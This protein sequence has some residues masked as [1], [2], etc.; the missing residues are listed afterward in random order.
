MK[1][2]QMR[3][4]G[5]G[6]SVFDEGASESEWDVSSPD[7]PSGGADTT[8]PMWT[9]PSD[10]P[11]VPVGYKYCLNPAVRGTSLS[12]N[13]PTDKPGWVAEHWAGK[14]G[15]LYYRFIKLSSMGTKIDE[16]WGCPKWNPS[17]AS[18]ADVMAIQRALNSAGQPGANGKALAVDGVIGQ[19]TCY[20]MYSYVYRT[21]G[22]ADP[23]LTETEFASLGLGG[24]GFGEKYARLCDTWYSGEFGKSLDE[25]KEAEQIREGEKEPP[26]LIQNHKQCW[27]GQVLTW[28]QGQQEPICPKP[29]TPTAQPKQLSKKCATGQT[30]T[31]MSNQAEPSC[32]A[33]KH[34]A[35]PKP[36]PVKAGFNWKTLGLVTLGVVVVAA[37][38]GA[39]SKKKKSKPKSVGRTRR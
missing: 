15:L 36:A 35:A 4:R 5:F 21:T 12:E 27:N 29:T 31:W 20:A 34:A 16:V 24:R 11:S 7:Q 39:M 19:N 26:A 30:L 10:A 3:V 38:A 14:D 28:M 13:G 25:L 22:V 8:P 2:H 32:P 17:V 6:A 1:F 9:P 33:V 23:T 18:K 37:I